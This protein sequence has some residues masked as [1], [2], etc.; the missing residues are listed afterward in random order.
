[1]QY[2][3]F[4]IL[5][6][7]RPS[8]NLIT[9]GKLDQDPDLLIHEATMEHY[10]LDDCK[11]KRHTTFTEAIEVANEMKAKTTIL[12][13]FSQRY[14]KIMPLDELKVENCDNIGIAFDFTS[15]SPKTF[16]VIRKTFPALEAIFETEM[17]EVL[18]KRINFKYKRIDKAIEASLNLE[19]SF[20]D[21][22]DEPQAKKS[23]T[24]KDYAKDIQ[25]T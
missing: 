7:T 20:A 11:A 3:I 12:T 22:S 19:E 17:E 15:I 6:D 5:G 23:K 4:H 8:T 2:L 14:S 9:F 1:M 21:E 16:N 13:H 25:N 10:M 18:R 24:F